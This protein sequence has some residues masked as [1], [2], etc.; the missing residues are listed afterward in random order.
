MYETN[1]IMIEIFLNIKYVS[2]EPKYNNKLIKTK[3]GKKMWHQLSVFLLCSSLK[4]TPNCVVFPVR[5]VYVLPNHNISRLRTLFIQSRFELHSVIYRDPTIANNCSQSPSY[6]QQN[7]TLVSKKK[8]VR[9]KTLNSKRQT[10]F[11]FSKVEP[12][13][14]SPAFFQWRKTKKCIN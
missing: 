14:F 9:L 6:H 3:T 8:I 7:H 10:T 4:T 5:F 13:K 2:N 11:I 12:S 1:L